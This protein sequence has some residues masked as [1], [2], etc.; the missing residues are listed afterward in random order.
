MSNIQVQLSDD[1]KYMR[2]LLDDPEIL[3]CVGDEDSPRLSDLPDFEIFKVNDYRLLKVTDDYVSIGV[4][5]LFP[6][7][8]RVWEIHTIMSKNCRGKKALEAGRLGLDHM[9][10]FEG[11]ESLMSRCPSDN[12]ACL[13]YA[14]ML[15]FHIVRSPKDW[16][17]NGEYI[18]SHHVEITRKEWEL[19]HC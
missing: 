8:P 9:F 18:T 19:C 16:K 3:A 17:R 14:Q 7:K 6:I 15:H 11:A 5:Y 4:F 13:L 2:S 1:F 10:L 12:P